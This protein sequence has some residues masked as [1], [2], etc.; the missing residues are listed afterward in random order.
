MKTVT[1]YHKNTGMLSPLT[2]VVSDDRMIE[3][4]T[5][6]DHVAIEHPKNRTPW[7]Y[8][9]H[10]FDIASNSIVDYQPPS[11]SHEHVWNTEL[12]RW[13]LHPEVLQRNMELSEARQRLRYL[14]AEVQPHAIREHA[15]GYEGSLERLKKLDDEVNELR[16]KLET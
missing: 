1:F 6:E 12:R 3:I 5:P 15:L 10:K 7:D 13:V 2:V 14:L 16:K 11:P 8:L 4:N 9:S